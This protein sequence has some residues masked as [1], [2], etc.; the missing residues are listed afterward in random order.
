MTEAILPKAPQAR[1]KDVDLRVFVDSDHAGEHA[2]RRSRTGY[3]LYLNM[4]PIAWF[5]KRQATIET[6]VFGAEFVTMKTAMDTARGIHYKLCMMGIPIGGP[7]YFYG[8]NMSVIHNTQQPESQLRKKANAICY[9]TIR[10]SVA[11]GEMLTGHVC[12]ENNPADICTK[13]VPGGQKR[14]HLLNLIMYDLA[15]YD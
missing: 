9:H 15:E 4:S 8:D 11:M 14:T 1:G 6:S 7:T 13:V 5:S 10:E 2:T 3:L 12:S